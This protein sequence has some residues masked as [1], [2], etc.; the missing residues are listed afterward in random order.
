MSGKLDQLYFCFGKT[1]CEIFD[2]VIENEVIR[3]ID[4]VG[5]IDNAPLFDKC[6]YRVGLFSMGY[7]GALDIEDE[8]LFVPR[9]ESYWMFFPDGEEFVPLIQ[10]FIELCDIEMQKFSSRKELI[11]ASKNMKCKT[12]K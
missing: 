8:R 3:H 7:N 4:V 12:L 10:I 11:E 5:N 1:I 2:F 9:S 6:I